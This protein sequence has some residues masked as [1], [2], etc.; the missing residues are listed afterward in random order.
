MID[1]SLCIEDCGILIG[2]FGNISALRGPDADS[3]TAHE[4]RRAY[5]EWQRTR[6]PHSMVYF[7]QRAY[8]PKTREE[9]DRWGQVLDFQRNFPKDGLWWSYKGKP[10]FEK[11]VL[12]APEPVHP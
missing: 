8:T 11:V 12:S 3:G 2:I 7:N 1:A 10:Q 6:R 4:F 9:T 5:E